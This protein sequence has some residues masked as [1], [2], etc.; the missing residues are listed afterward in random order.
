MN[1]VRSA[2]A[3][4]LLLGFGTATIGVMLMGL[5][6]WLIY[7]SR[8]PGSGLIEYIVMFPQAVPRLGFAFR[9]MWAWV[10]FPIPVYG[11]LCLLF[12]APPTGV[13]H[14]WGATLAAS[15]FHV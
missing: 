8:L 9:L 15:H 10:A 1:A 5:L 2:L 4:S 3:N 14:A 13:L 6:A 11:T 7:R 12:P